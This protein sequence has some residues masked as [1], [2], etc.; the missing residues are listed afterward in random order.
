MKDGGLPLPAMNFCAA[1]LPLSFRACGCGSKAAF[2]FV[3]K[4]PTLNSLH[5]QVQLLSTNT[6]CNS[7]AIGIGDVD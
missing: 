1:N 6:L 3:I 5:L 7:L 2:T 4:R